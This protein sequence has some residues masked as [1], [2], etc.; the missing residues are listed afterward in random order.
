MAQSGTKPLDDFHQ[1]HFD[2]IQA[3][4]GITALFIL[5]EHIRFLNCGAFGVDIFFCISGFMILFSTHSDS[6]F[7]LRKRLI[8]ILPL[9][10]LMTLGTF[11]LLLLFPRMFEQTRANPVFLLKSF[12]FLPFDIGGGVLQPL[13][14]IGWTVNC[15]I[16]FYFL[17]A[18]AMRIS[19]KYRGLY[20]GLFLLAFVAAARLLPSPPAFLAFY[21][22]PVMLEFRHDLLRS[23][24]GPVPQPEAVPIL[25]LF[26][27]SP[28]RRRLPCPGPHQADRQYSGIPQTSCVG[29]SRLSHCAVRLSDRPVFFRGRRGY[30]PLMPGT[31]CAAIQQ[32]RFIFSYPPRRGRAAF[33][34]DFLTRPCAIKQGNALLHSPTRRVH[35]AS[36]TIFLM[37]PRAHKKA[38]PSGLAWQY[39]LFTLPG[40]LLSCHASGP[41]SL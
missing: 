24:P 7:F 12:L 13:M 2:S 41:G 9:Y 30:F 4:R 26:Y 32:G 22:N 1:M 17:F 34:A 10:Y 39:Q 36:A 35:V 16:F 20:C 21:G 27:H 18:I 23:G 33:A 25:P 8:R 6:R 14:R 5:L 15:E 40:S 31:V 29:N 37:H 38:R 28:S 3:L 19:H 11:L